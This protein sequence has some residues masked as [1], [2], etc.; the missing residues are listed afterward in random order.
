ML[1]RIVTKFSHKVDNH[2]VLH[3][4]YKKQNWPMC[5]D[6]WFSKIGSHI[7]IYRLTVVSRVAKKLQSACPYKRCAANTVSYIRV[8]MVLQY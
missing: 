6:V 8:G 7:Y 2:S 5:P 1:Q 3:C 4:S